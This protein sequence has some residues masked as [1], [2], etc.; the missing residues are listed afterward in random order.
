[1]P[2]SF[3]SNLRVE[4][5][6]T[7]ENTGTWGTL[8][9]QIFDLFDD[10][11]AGVQDITMTDATYTL[12]TVEG[13]DDESRAAVINV[14]GTTT[15]VRDITLP[16]FSKLYIF[17][18]NLTSG[19][20]DVRA[21]IGGTTVS[22]PYGFH[23][24]VWT[25]GTSCFDATN[26]ITERWQDWGGSLATTG[27]ADAYLLTTNRTLTAYADGEKVHVVANF[28]N[29]GAATINVDSVGVKAIR[30]V[31]TTGDIALIANDIVSAGH[32]ILQYDA[33]ANTAA[34]A[35]IVLNPTFNSSN[36]AITGGSITGITDLAVADGGTGASDAATAR[37][38]LGAI[39]TLVEDTTPQLG[40]F[41]DPNGAYI[42]MDKGG[43]IASASPLVIDTD[44]DAFDVT[45]TT[46]FAAMTVAANRF[47]Y[48]QFDGALTMT[49]HATNLNLPGGANITTAAGDRGLFYSTGTDT[50]HCIAFVKASGLP[51]AVLD[52]D[53]FA[54]DSA[55][56]V[57]TQQSIKAYV[58]GLI[59][60]KLIVREEQT[61][62][63]NGHAGATFTSGGNRTRFLNATQV[64]TITGASLA[65]N[66]ITLPAGTYHCQASA[67]SFKVGNNLAW[68]ANITDTA[69]E[70]LGTSERS[71]AADG[72]QSRS[73]VD[74]VFTIAAEKVFE[75]QHR[76][77]STRANDGFG[78][79]AGI[80]T[81]VY[82]VVS[83]TK[84][85]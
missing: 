20:D 59:N 14:I 39:A 35:W 29:T 69:V 13:A 32:Y 60:Q 12:S 65:T 58:D 6:A 43:D 26:K 22:I 38:N 57:P 30:K 78:S 31:D 75:L 18:N 54:S 17:Y 82:S 84:L 21:S 47:F 15:A 53:D 50:V 63:T 8:A 85:A 80:T 76:C 44:G 67:P 74:G 40:G 4:K 56:H 33:S 24:R 9:N 5:Q 64:N 55:A 66:Q 71:E 16:A 62:G 52:E 72:V 45:G 77:N 7:G 42:G 83:I 2:S 28:A 10:A 27:S 36:V 48:L 79:N 81:E 25:D 70:I 46:G 73:F 3:S 23:K 41:L 49:H 11:I 37:T 68:L 34:G 61:A 1:M 19:T 51:I